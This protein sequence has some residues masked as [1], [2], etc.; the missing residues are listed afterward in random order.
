MSEWVTVREFATRLEAEVARARLES[1]DIP[2]TITA[3]EAGAFGP[4]FQGMVPSGV[5]LRV[6]RERVAAARVLVAED[7]DLTG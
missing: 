7:R 1:A 2:V 4:G 5:E 6:P 3:H